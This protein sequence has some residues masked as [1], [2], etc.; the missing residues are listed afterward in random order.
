MPEELSPRE[1]VVRDCEI[2]I[3]V[4]DGES[5][6]DAGKAYGVSEE[7]VVQIVKRV[8]PILTKEPS[9]SSRRVNL[10][11]KNPECGIEFSVPRS[12]ATK[13]KEFCSKA[14]RSAVREAK[15]QEAY[16]L[17]Q[18][19]MRWRLINQRLGFDRDGSGAFIAA[20]DYAQKNK[21][22]FP[23]LLPN[24]QGWI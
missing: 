10:T 16:E 24:E 11:C 17:R 4:A 13:G 18:S 19:G 9:R 21:R 20:R 7:R 15:G 6:V 12:V 2:V 3:M 1:R 8:A 5:Y 22:G 14:C 23:P